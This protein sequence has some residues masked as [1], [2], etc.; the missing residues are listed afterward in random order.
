MTK[1]SWQMSAYQAHQMVKRSKE[2]KRQDTLQ[3]HQGTEKSLLST[4]RRGHVAR[5]AG[6]RSPIEG[7]FSNSDR[8]RESKQERHQANAASRPGETATYGLARG[9]SMATSVYDPT[10]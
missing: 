1:K 2:I 9:D 4:G 5:Q 7:M 8:E 10:P 3:K 6:A